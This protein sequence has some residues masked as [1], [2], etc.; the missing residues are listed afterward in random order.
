LNAYEVT[1]Q[2]FV[3]LVVLVV[4]VLKGAFAVILTSFV[5]GST[6]EVISASLVGVVVGH[7]FP[8]WL[9]FKGGRG[10]AAAAG[11]MLA[12]SWI[13]VVMWLGCWTVGY[14]FSKNVHVGNIV[15]ILASPLLGYLL[16][17]EIILKFTMA[18]FS[19]AQIL[20]VYSVMSAVLFIRHIGPLRDL[21]TSRTTAGK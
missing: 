7:C 19:A 2:R 13:F 10:L 18:A 16:P 3:G 6:F 8:V 5:W 14:S 20:V 17:K 1:G 4:D 11:A 12:V 9:M 15:A 21:I